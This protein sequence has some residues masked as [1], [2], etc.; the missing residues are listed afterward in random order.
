MPAANVR[1]DGT[2]N[3]EPRMTMAQETR[4]GGGVVR[5]AYGPVVAGTTGSMGRTQ[6]FRNCTGLP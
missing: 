2:G 6:M 5:P 4:C 1:R 3:T